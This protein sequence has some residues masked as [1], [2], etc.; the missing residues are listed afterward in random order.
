MELRKT[1]IELEDLLDEVRRSNKK[2]YQAMQDR[3]Q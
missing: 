3:I 1:K 2:E